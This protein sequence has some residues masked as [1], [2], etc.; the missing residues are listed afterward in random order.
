MDF[1]KLIIWELE[2]YNV[3]AYRCPKLVDQLEVE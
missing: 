2:Y 1:T 3:F